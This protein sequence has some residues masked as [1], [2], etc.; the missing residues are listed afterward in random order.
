MS[1]ICKYDSQYSRRKFLSNTANGILG[2]GVL[3]SAWDLFAKTG[4]TASAYPEELRSIEQYTRGK[5]KA[6]D[7]IT[8][9]NVHLVKDL[10]DGVRL[11]QIQ[12]MGRRLKLA[13][14]TTELNK[15]NPVDYIEATLRN[16][17]LGAFDSSGNVTTKDGKPWIGGNPFPEPK[18]AMEV[19]AAH[20]LSWGRHDACLYVSK[21][22][23]IDSSGALQYEYST[24]WAEMSTVG[25]I[26]MDP[27]PY[28]PNF[29]DKL[30]YQSVF[31][32]SPTD[33]KGVA[34]LNI[35]PYDQRQFP[36]LYGYIPAFK[37]TRR[38]P[39]NQRFEPLNPGSELYLSDA[40]AAGDPFLTWGD[41]QIVGR[42]P[43]L[44]AVSNG[45]NGDHP[46]WEHSTQGGPSGNMFWETTVE[47]VPEAIIVEAKPTS[48]PR[49]PVSK[50]RVW[51]DARTQM[52]LSMV[53]YDRRGEMFRFFDGAY[54]LYENGTKRVMDGKNTY[55]S[56]T[57]LHAFN[58][59]TNKM[60]R[61]EQV[62]EIDGGNHKMRV[63]D[64]IIFEK[65]LTMNS[66]ER[67]G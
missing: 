25:R 30:R 5:L 60:T 8:K 55:W 50:K 65:Y 14:T 36:E 53:S 23:D 6:G 47:L 22:Y 19:F 66:L 35:W 15:L 49:S 27:K 4:E 34:Y 33:L 45:W 56:W 32:T 42:G 26:S 31:F 40:W 57:A 52:P 67:L 16:R 38:F 28:L 2:A 37:R 48:Y 43:Y 1:W 51:F 39:T 58:V 61:I 62:R 11:K 20:T 13:P 12:E 3:C 63:N 18:N 59:Q 21:E 64:P 29:E 41:Y 46:N 24:G 9:D 17:G 44:A 7:Y 54:G 10:L